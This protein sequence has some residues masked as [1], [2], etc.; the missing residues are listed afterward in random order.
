[1]SPSETER[2]RAPLTGSVADVCHD[3]VA[4]VLA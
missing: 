2:T 4:T 3:L 1:M